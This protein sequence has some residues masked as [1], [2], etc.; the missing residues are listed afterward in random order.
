MGAALKN[1]YNSHWIHV[2]KDGEITPKQFVPSPLQTLSS[3]KRI[4]TELVVGSE[5]QVNTNSAL[6]PN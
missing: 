6:S 5:N 4:F 1:G 2:R 3:E